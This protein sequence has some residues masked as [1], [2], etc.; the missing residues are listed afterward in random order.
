MKK[1]TEGIIS[2]EFLKVKNKLVQKKIT[3]EINE[4]TDFASFEVSP[5]GANTI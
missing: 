4:N 3:D 1:E 2:D 5:Y